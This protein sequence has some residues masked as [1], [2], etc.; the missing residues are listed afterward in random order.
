MKMTDRSGKL[1]IR[2][3]DSITETLV[4]VNRALAMEYA[5]VRPDRRASVGVILMHSDGNYMTINMGPAL[6]ERGYRVL[7]CESIQ[8][9]AMEPKLGR[10]HGFVK[11]L[12]A[13][14]EIKK[15]VLMGHSG[16]ATLMT[17]YQAMAENGLAAYRKNVLYPVRLH[18][19]LDPADGIMLI[20]ANYGNGVMTLLSI[21]PAVKKEGDGIH[22]DPAYDIFAPENGYD[23]NGASYST[24]F[25]RRYNRAQSAR[26]NRL[27]DYALDRLK[28]IENGE[29]CYTDDEPFDITAGAQ[30]KPCNR[31]LPQDPR[32]LSHT[33]REHDL[34]WG[35]G[36]VTHEI[37]RCLRGAEIDSNPTPSIQAVNQ[38]TVRSF[39]SSQA[40]RSNEKLQVLEDGIEGVEW[41]SA[42][43]SPIGNIEDISCPGLFM[44]MTG[45]YEYLAAEMIYDH[46]ARMQD[47]SIAFVRGAG[48]MFSPNRRAESFPGE[49]GDTEKV[50]YDHMAV[51]LER[52]A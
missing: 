5:P 8:G 39:L 33:K 12:K 35:D 46:A 31:L 40:I 21:D 47:K 48:H 19:E 38:T 43:T 3:S 29:G 11:Y 51:W 36:K 30:P 6:A 7:A 44:G 32:L 10:L 34:L 27:I 20:D 42:Y 26:D 22:L 45:S 50:L 28:K 4:S 16:G 14:P 13:D 52:F 15:I 9:G 17:A 23:P 18:E 49:F 25:I 2:K 37:V 24:D 41:K 1:Q